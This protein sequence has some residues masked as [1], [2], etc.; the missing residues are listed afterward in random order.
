MKTNLLILVFSGLFLCVFSLNLTAQKHA[1]NQLFVRFNP[2][3]TLK[4][5]AQLKTEL[6][7]Q[8]LNTYDTNWQLW[9][10]P[11]SEVT[12]RGGIEAIIQQYG[13]DGGEVKLEPNYQIHLAGLPTDPEFASQWY[14]NN[15]GIKP[16]QVAG[17]HVDALK[18][19]EIRKESPDE[20]VAILDTGI[21]WKHP[22]LV[23]NIWQNLGEDADGD[24][25]VLVYTG[26]AW[27]FDP[28][29]MNGIDD[30]GNG[31]ID[32][33]IGWDFVNNDNDPMD[34]M[35]H[36]THV[37]GILA[38]EGN[39]IGISGIT[40]QAQLMA[41]QIFDFNTSYNSQAILALEY[42]RRNG[43]KVVNNSWGGS[44]Y[45]QPLYN[46]IDSSS[47]NNI[48][49]ACAAGNYSWNWP[50][51]DIDAKPFYPAS[52]DLD[53]II[54]VAATK[55]NDLLWDTSNYGAINV[56]LAAP[57]VDIFSTQVSTNS[58]QYGNKS[59]TSMAT[60]L[61]AGAAALLRAECPNLSPPQIRY[62]LMSTVDTLASLSSY[63]QSSGRLNLH[64]ALEGVTGL[65]A[66]FSYTINGLSASF[67]PDFSSNLA[68]W[69]WDFG[70]GGQNNEQFPIHTFPSS[71]VYEVCLE[72]EN[73]CGVDT[74]CRYVTVL[75]DSILEGCGEVWEH[76]PSARNVSGLQFSGDTIWI[77]TAFSG[78][79]G[80][81]RITGGYD[82]FNRSSSKVSIESERYLVRATSD[83]Y[84][85][86]SLN[87]GLFKFNRINKTFEKLG[88][89]YNRIYAMED[90]GDGNLLLG[91][92]T[93]GAIIYS[94][95]DALL[96]IKPTDH[97]MPNNRVTSGLLMENG[98]LVL[99]TYNGGIGYYLNDTLIQLNTTNTLALPSNNI[100][101]LLE[102]I[103]G[104]IWVATDKGIASVDTL[105]DWTSYVNMDSSLPLDKNILHL[106][107]DS[108]NTLWAMTEQDTLLRFDGQQWNAYS[109]PL[110]MNRLDFGVM[111]FDENDH[112]WLGGGGLKGIHRFTGTDWHEE[113]ITQIPALGVTSIAKDS[114]GGKWMGNPIGIF[115]GGELVNWA[116]NDSSF[117][118]KQN[119][120]MPYSDITSITIAQNGNILLGSLDNQVPF[121]P[122]NRLMVY[123]T[124]QNWTSYAIPGTGGITAI[125]EDSTSGFW[126]GTST[127]GLVYLDNGITSVYNVDNSNLPSN[128][129]NALACDQNN[130]LWVATD[131]GIY[132]FDNEIVI[133]TSNSDFL[134]SNSI[135]KLAFNSKNELFASTEQGLY[136]TNQAIEINYNTANS[137]LP[138]DNVGAIAI[139]GNDILWVQADSSLIRIFE[140]DWKVMGSI[141]P[142][143]P[144]SQGYLFTDI[145]IEG[146]KKWI[147]YL[148]GLTILEDRFA[149]FTVS[150]TCSQTLTFENKSTNFTD[151]YWS[152][153]GEM[154]A[155]TE[156]FTYTFPSTGAY[157]IELIGFD[158]EYCFDS[159]LKVIEIKPNAMDI[160]IGPDTL[161]V[162]AD[163]FLLEAN[164]QGM[165]NYQWHEKLPNNSFITLDTTYGMMISLSG[166]YVLFVTDPCGKVWGDAI[167]V[168]LLGEQVY[169]GD[170]NYDGEVNINDFLMYNF[171]FGK[172][173]PVRPNA[174]LDWRPQN[175]QNW[176]KITPDELNIKH[177]DAN[178]DGIV[179]YDD[180]LA[181]VQNYGLTHDN[182][183]PPSTIPSNYP[184]E[185]SFGTPFPSALGTAYVLNVPLH[186][187]STSPLDVGGLSLHLYHSRDSIQFEVVMGAF[188]A[189]NPEY[190]AHVKNHPNK[191]T[192]VGISRTDGQSF[193][194]NGIIGNVVFIIQEI[195]L[196][197]GSETLP[198]VVDIQGGLAL[199]HLGDSLLIGN[200]SAV[201]DIGPFDEGTSSP[202]SSFIISSSKLNM[203]CEHLG[204]ITANVYGGNPPFYYNWSNGTNGPTITD[205]LPGYYTLTVT[206]NNEIKTSTILIENESRIQANITFLNAIGGFSNGEAIANPSGG[207][208]NYNYLWSNGASTATIT[209]LQAGSYRLTLSDGNGCLAYDQVDLLNDPI[210]LN[211]KVILEGAYDTT[212][213]RMK[214]DLCRNEL[215]PSFSP[216]G[217]GEQVNIDASFTQDTTS[218]AVVDWV[219][220]ELRAATFPYE[221]LDRKA[222]FL[223]RDG[224]I[225]NLDG[226]SIIQF[227][228]VP[229]G[230]YNCIIR[231]RNHLAVMTTS[232][233]WMG[234][235]QTTIDFTLSNSYLGTGGFGQNYIDGKWMLYTGDANQDNEITAPDKILFSEDNGLFGEY[236]IPDFDL[237]GD[238]NGVDKTIWSRNNGISSRVPR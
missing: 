31:Y 53:N 191:S 162:Y 119:S 161:R 174:S 220:V 232:P 180:S 152:V 4:N 216:Y 71:G 59:G 190:I 12:Q 94:P 60:P 215:L 29:D 177:S 194:V 86:W 134:K 46:E 187:S 103:Y 219:L 65:D 83:E 206:S 76:I 81:N 223:Q 85:L 121:Y 142:A 169:P 98:A 170:L 41:L 225:V 87:E 100:N 124:N 102:D 22:D 118:N 43:A 129:I 222:A 154:M 101:D 131:R 107:L 226:H 138:A 136:Y 16:D 45:N 13:K 57:G 143:M 203:T 73:F 184:I 126:M 47:N 33:F 123:D 164:L 79:I 192:E 186:L 227:R 77:L 113:I 14:L 221:L 25:I 163:S 78:L 237:N 70:D 61:V 74:V 18:A 130:T 217:T 115:G 233:I 167:N 36:G 200:K 50:W 24:G 168:E 151:F 199:N 140:N 176:S 105:G 229:L 66:S 68:S 30:D 178:G 52:Y 58:I 93:E 55:A 183:R 51:R 175:A 212:N 144:P 56:D 91:F 82:V 128:V 63:C 42:A 15:L 157:E 156:D 179:N 97:G 34:L 10:L 236:R 209:G 6:K 165:T 108:E 204:E 214:N 173:G 23:N 38:A 80:Y 196:P 64:K 88:V 230:N 21:D 160:D 116:S 146:D 127:E 35:G 110:G 133:D 210:P 28:G 122:P 2:E 153:D 9:E 44:G 218:N 39:T 201:Y 11:S 5:R 158:E 111:K 27:I 150:D 197:V 62:A 125:L 172:T 19:W 104:S 231:H 96:Q 92:D 17:A 54:A 7:A 193:D 171:A 67:T 166:H 120:S 106:S 188:L 213:T 195:D 112:L 182:G 185:V 3:T 109:T 90:L 20:I 135:R 238:V 84:Y 1:D 69:S 137:N 32:D 149:A 189:D 155:N 40:K 75:D 147:G 198:L 208:G 211:V 159:Y 49:M 207:D 26:A 224:D 8:I 139:D 117:F 48:L 99:G 235:T 228:A 234:Y 114:S 37:A 89:H 132:N 181:I 148:T 205:L 95:N 141:F 202:T 145:M 72:K